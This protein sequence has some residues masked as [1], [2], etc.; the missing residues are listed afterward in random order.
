MPQEAAKGPQRG[1]KRPQEA[2]RRPLVHDPGTVAGWA[3]GHEIRRP[4][5][6]Y[7]RGAWRARLIRFWFWFFFQ[8]NS[9]VGSGP[10]RRPPGRPA[11]VLSSPIS[12][13]RRLQ[14]GLQDASKTARMASKTAKMA[15]RCLQDGPRWL[16]DG[17]DGSKMSPRRF[18][19]PPTFPRGLRDGPR[20]L[21]EDLQ[22]GP[23]MPNSL[24][25]FR[26]LKGFGFCASSAFRRLKTAQEAVKIAPRAPKKPPR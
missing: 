22:E 13:P 3:E 10:S 18:K 12:C 5:L 26:F 17:Q 6:I 24:T 21:Q 7:H 25:F 16:Q 14:D 19:R 20:G 15:L 1:C 9:P 8:K 11:N 23:Q 2:S 4:L